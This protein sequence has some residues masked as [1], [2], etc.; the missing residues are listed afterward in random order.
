MNYDLEAATATNTSKYC[1]S[2]L[3]DPLRSTNITSPEDLKQFSRM[4]S[5]G[6]NAKAFA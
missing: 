1:S 2:G 4:S 5:Q 6:T 3:N